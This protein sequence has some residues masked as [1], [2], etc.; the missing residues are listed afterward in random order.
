MAGLIRVKRWLPF[1]SGLSPDL[2][3]KST[4]VMLP[5]AENVNAT[6]PVRSRMLEKYKLVDSV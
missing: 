6:E 4:S 3:R 5:R 2:S 1:S